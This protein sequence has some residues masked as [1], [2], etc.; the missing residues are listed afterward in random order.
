MR[1][2]SIRTAGTLTFIFVP[3][4]FISASASFYY[5]DLNYFN[6]LNWSQG[7]RLAGIVWSV[8]AIV[9]SIKT[10]LDS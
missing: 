1:K 9:I 5:L 3:L 10:M 8:I 7:A 4:I 6:P 2:F